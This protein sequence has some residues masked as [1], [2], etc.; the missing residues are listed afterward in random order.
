MA[1][2]TN[3]NWKK[4]LSVI[5]LYWK[6]L[7]WHWKTKQSL[8]NKIKL[9]IKYE[10]NILFEFWCVF[11]SQS[12]DFFSWCQS[13]YTDHVFSVTAFQFQLPVT[14]LAGRAGVDGRGNGERDLHI[15]CLLW[16]ECHWTLPDLTSVAKPLDAWRDL[17]PQ[18]SLCIC[19]HRELTWVKVLTSLI[20][21]WWF[22]RYLLE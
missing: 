2:K 18:A 16:W 5:Y 10:C 21:V 15:I 8:K 11:Q 22:G 6:K 3:L 17:N 14:V 9:F 4:T 20:K 13:F 1:L 19:F 7:Y 12:S